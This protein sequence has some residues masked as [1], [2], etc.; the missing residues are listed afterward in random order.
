MSAKVGIYSEKELWMEQRNRIFTDQ[1][2]QGSYMKI[3]E[4]N[5]N[6][7][8]QEYVISK[9]YKGELKY[10]KQ[11]N[12]CKVYEILGIPDDDCGDPLVVTVSS[13]GYC[14]IKSYFKVLS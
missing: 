13:R 7:I 2:K 3:D 10:L 14:Q 8:A 1:M 12:G 4:I 5:S 6:K 9:G 11:W